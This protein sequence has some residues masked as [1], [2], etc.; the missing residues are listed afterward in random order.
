MPNRPRM[1]HQRISASL[2]R[3]AGRESIVVR[4]PT[5]DYPYFCL[6]ICINMSIVAL[7]FSRIAAARSRVA[8]VLSS[9]LCSNL[10]RAA[11]LR[12]IL[13]SEIMT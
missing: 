9:R 13:Y 1:N 11:S 5:I 6:A 12:A 10:A 2:F 3:L 8:D 7:S 4:T